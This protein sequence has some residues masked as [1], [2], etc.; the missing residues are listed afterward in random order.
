[1]L[2]NNNDRIVEDLLEAW[3]CGDKIAENK[4]MELLYP[5]IHKIAHF[6]LKSNHASSLQT[7]EIVSEAFLKLDQQKSVKWKNQSHFLAITA[8]VIRRVL[9]D[10]FRSTSSDKRGGNEADMTIE[11]FENFIED[12]S[13]FGI[14]WLSINHLL[15]QLHTIDPDAATVLEYKVFGGLTHIEMAEVMSVS[16]STILRNWNFARSWI[17]RKLEK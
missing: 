4:L 15:K 12:S 17:I 10:H 2:E 9:I 11:R 5:D 16:E 7:T 14:D 13:Q 6:Q 8:K 1:M 3:S